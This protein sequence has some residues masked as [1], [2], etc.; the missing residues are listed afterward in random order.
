MLP[1]V[2][3]NEDLTRE[4]SNL[5]YVARQ[6]KRRERILDTFTR[7]GRVYMRCTPEDKPVVIWDMNGIMEKSGLSRPQP[8]P[9]QKE[10][11][12]ASS[13]AMS[14][15]M[16]QLPPLMSMRPIPRNAITSTPSGDKPDEAPAHLSRF[17]GG[18]TAGVTENYM[19]DTDNTTEQDMTAEPDQEMSPDD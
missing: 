16:F 2:Y 12:V 18:A 13:S 4:N 3:I 15:S 1:G 19:Y 14:K 6:L 7:D 11:S 10:R 5:A 17:G 9:A 8:R